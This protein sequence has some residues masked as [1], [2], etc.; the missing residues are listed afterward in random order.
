V[1]PLVSKVIDA[2]QAMPRGADFVFPTIRAKQMTKGA[3][4]FYWDPVRSAFRQTVTAERWKDLC[5]GQPD[6][7][8][9]SLRHHAASQVVAR[10]GNEY[11]C[12]A[13]LGNTPEVCREVYI[14]EYAQL[15][16]DR[17]RRFLEPPEIVDLGAAR[18]RR[19]GGSS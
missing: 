9:Y 10:G 7:A 8:L 14:H 1:L 17:L 16:R 11:D 12:A 6:L 15:Q 13:L 4:R 2:I 5:E 18:T 3:S 19:M